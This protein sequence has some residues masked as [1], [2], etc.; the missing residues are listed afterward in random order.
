MRMRATA[1]ELFRKNKAGERVTKGWY[2][3]TR[4]GQK[5]TKRRAKSQESAERIASQINAEEEAADHW[6]TGG[7][8]PCDEALRGW[9]KTHEAELSPSTAATHRSSIE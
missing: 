7:A 5:Q 1:I 6:M 3:I 9:L 8:L 4:E 2:V